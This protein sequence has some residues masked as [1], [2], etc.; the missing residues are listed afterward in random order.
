MQL[1]LS[2]MLQ[3]VDT[4]RMITEA[5]QLVEAERM[6]ARGPSDNG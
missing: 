2:Y 4:N 1:H 6:N 3:S 5:L